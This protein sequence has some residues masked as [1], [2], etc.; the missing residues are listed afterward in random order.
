MPNDGVSLGTLLTIDD[1][2]FDFV[3]LFQGFVS[4]DLNRRVMHEHIRSVF[5]TDETEAFCVIEPFDRAFELS[6]SVLPSLID[7]GDVLGKPL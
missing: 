5:T 7:S 6:H 3:T 2:K 4:I 1:V